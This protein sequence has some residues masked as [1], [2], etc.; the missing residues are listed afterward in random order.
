MPLVLRPE[1]E[2]IVARLQE[3]GSRR[4]P[5]ARLDAII[6]TLPFAALVADDA[7][8]FVSVNLEAAAVSGYTVPQL[9]RLSVWELTPMH[10]DGDAE[11]L[12]RLFIRYGA[13]SGDYTIR[14]KSGELVALK[15]AARTNILPGLHLSLLR[16]TA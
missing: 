5:A 9:L 13:Q 15:Y 8:H 10:L 7:G 3:P 4:D 14:T 11:H 1:L 12:W 2:Q 6:Q 16:H